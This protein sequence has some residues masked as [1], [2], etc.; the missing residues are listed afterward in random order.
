MVISIIESVLA[1][2]TSENAYS[3]KIISDFMTT[4]RYHKCLFCARILT[5]IDLQLNLQM[6]TGKAFHFYSEGP[7]FFP[8]TYKYDIGRNEYDTS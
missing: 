7:V 2:K 5:D 6:V 3:R 8:P 4:T 1:I